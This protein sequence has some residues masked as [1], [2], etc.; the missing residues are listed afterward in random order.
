MYNCASVT[1][2]RTNIS[3]IIELQHGLLIQATTMKQRQIAFNTNPLNP[4]FSNS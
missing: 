2:T 3:L 1:E 4:P